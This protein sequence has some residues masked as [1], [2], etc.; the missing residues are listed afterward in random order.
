[1]KST[2]R[3]LVLAVALLTVPAVTAPM[4]GCS[5]NQHVTEDVRDIGAVYIAT[6]STLNSARRNGLIDFETWSN[7]INPFIQQGRDIYIDMK[8]AAID[9]D[10]TRVDVLEASLVGIVS[11]LAAAADQHKEQ[12]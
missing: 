9:G 11:R 3:I 5:G 12:P 7:D 10:A 6:V 1:M 4:T 8:Q 2:F